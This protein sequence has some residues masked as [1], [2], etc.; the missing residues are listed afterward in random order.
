MFLVEGRFARSSFLFEGKK[1]L[2]Q[3]D[4]MAV[5]RK[6][7]K[8]IKTNREK[9]IKYQILTY[10]FFKDIKVS[11][12][13]LELLFELSNNDGIEMNN[14]CEH[15]S[16]KKIY[17]TKQSAR[18][19]ITKAEKKTLIIKGGDLRKKKVYISENLNIHKEA[20]IFLDIKILGK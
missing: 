20:I 14:L 17:G 7:E 13:E 1:L 11:S 12:T 6:I 16:E 5:V 9:L 10:C 19:A 18:N 4:I 2:E 3:R 15:L 8:K